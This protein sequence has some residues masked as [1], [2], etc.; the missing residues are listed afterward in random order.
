[1]KYRLKFRHLLLGCLITLIC[2]LAYFGEMISPREFNISIISGTIGVIIGALTTYYIVE[3]LLEER[4]LSQVKPI[5][6]KILSSRLWVVPRVILIDLNRIKNRSDDELKKDVKARRLSSY[7]FVTIHRNIE[8]I[9]DIYGDRLSDQVVEKLVDFNE[10]TGL[11]A[12][13][14][15]HIQLNLE[16]IDTLDEWKYLRRDIE[17]FIK[18]FDDLANFLTENDLLPRD[19]LVRYKKLKSIPYTKYTSL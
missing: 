9:I 4:R 17:A 2:E 12:D 5:S 11:L 3:K 18:D 19:F 10:T 13:D 14:L 1:M 7:V 6:R 16:I 15:S 8:E